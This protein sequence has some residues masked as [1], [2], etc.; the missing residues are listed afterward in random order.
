MNKNF[1]MSEKLKKNCYFKPGIQ[2]LFCQASFEEIK[3]AMASFLE[4]LM[5]SKPKTFFLAL[6]RQLHNV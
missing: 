2:K 5:L 4:K 1:F 6:Y 3:K